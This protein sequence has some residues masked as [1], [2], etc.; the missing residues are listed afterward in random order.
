[1]YEAPAL[2]ADGETFW[3]DVETLQR[4]LEASKFLY[5]VR[6]ISPAHQ[7]CRCL[8]HTLGGFNKVLQNLRGLVPRVRCS[9]SPERV[10]IPTTAANARPRR[11]RSPA[12]LPSSHSQSRSSQREHKV[13]HTHLPQGLINSAQSQNETQLS[14]NGIGLGSF[15]PGD[16]S[17]ASRALYI[18]LWLLRPLNGMLWMSIAW[19]TERCLALRCLDLRIWVNL[20][21]GLGLGLGLEGLYRFQT[22]LSNCGVHMNLPT[23]FLDEKVLVLVSF[24]QMYFNSLLSFQMRVR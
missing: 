23:H 22:L 18:I 2:D 10:G 9:P 16:F 17:I 12:R 3:E 19:P 24:V 5:R 21:R 6:N 20:T 14:V 4:I 13:I 7:Q 1:M 15:T 8:R 11:C